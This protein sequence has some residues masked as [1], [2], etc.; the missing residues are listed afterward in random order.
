V[1]DLAKDYYAII[2]TV[3]FQHALKRRRTC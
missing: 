3:V 1:R 2:M